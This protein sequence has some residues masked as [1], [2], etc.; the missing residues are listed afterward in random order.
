MGH[1][2][3]S[4]ARNG[5]YLITQAAYNLLG[6]NLRLRLYSNQSHSIPGFL[7]ASALVST[8][9]ES[10]SLFSRKLESLRYKTEN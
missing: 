1:F 6:G 5:T 10:V 7:S 4:T 3:D 9:D 2:L 8:K